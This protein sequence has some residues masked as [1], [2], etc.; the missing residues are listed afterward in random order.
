M[1]S[2]PISRHI[3]PFL[4]NITSSIKSPSCIK[5]SFFITYIG[6]N[7]VT[8]CTIQFE[9]SKPLNIIKLFIIGLYISISKE[10]FK[11]YGKLFIIIVCL[12]F[13]VFFLYLRNLKILS[14]KPSSIDGFVNFMS[15]KIF[16]FFSKDN[17]FSFIFLIKFETE[18]IKKEYVQVPMIKRIIWKN[19]SLIVLPY[20]SPYPTVVI[21]AIK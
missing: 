1:K 6:L 13:S 15:F 11:E 2:I 20:I 14:Y 17:D 3:I 9:F 4:I 8:N 16:N 19:I 10:F 5:I 12:F 7:A 21:V 18:E